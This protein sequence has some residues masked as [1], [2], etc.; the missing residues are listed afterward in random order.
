MVDR[1]TMKV[2]EFHAA[3]K[4]QGVPRE[5]V[6][7]KCQMCHTIQSM[8]DMTRAGADAE[9]YFGFSALRN[10]LLKC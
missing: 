9:R 6:A 10:N 3:V 5:H 4:A 2:D 7:A 8:S 1:Q